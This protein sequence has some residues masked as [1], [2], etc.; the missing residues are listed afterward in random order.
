[1]PEPVETRRKEAAQRVQL[2]QAQGG[3]E[4]THTDFKNALE[5]NPRSHAKL[6]KHV[7]AFANTPRRTDAYIIFGV[8]EDKHLR[9]F[10]H[11]GVSESGFPAPETIYNLLRHYTTLSDVFVDAY[12]MLNGKLTPYVTIP[13][14]YEGPYA[15]SRSLQGAP[16]ILAAG[17][18]VCRYGSSSTRATERDVHRMQSDWGTWFL[19]CRYEKSAK[20]LVDTL[21]KRFPN[22]MALEDK[23]PYVRMV[24]G[25]AITDEFGTNVAPVLVHAYP[26]FESVESEAVRTLVADDAKPAFGKTLIGPRFSLATKETAARSGV[27]C[28]PLEEIYFVNDPYALLCRAFLQRWEKERSSHHIHFIVDLDYKPST[29]SALDGANRSILTFLEEQLATPE[30]VAI[31]IHG[32]FGGGKTTTAKQLVAELCSEYLRGN[33]RVPKVIYVD[34]NS[35]DVKSRRDECIEVELGKYRLP[36]DCVDGLITQVLEDE[37]HLIFDGV[38]EMARPNTPEGRQQALELLNDIGNRRAAIYLVRSS[39]FPSLADMICSVGLLADHD[40]AGAQKRLVVAHIL[41]LRQEQVNCYLDAR[42]GIEDARAVRSSLMQAKLDSFLEDPLIIS[43]VAQLVEAHGIGGLGALPRKGERAH[44]L[45][46]L[47]EQLLKREQTKRKRHRGLDFDQFQR[48]LHVVAFNL[49]CRG[50]GTITPPQL[51][52]FVSRAVGPAPDPVEAVN[53]FRTMSWIHRS[54]DGALSFRHEA[55]TVVCA[56]EHICTAFQYRNTLALGEW[57]SS[58]PLAPVVCDCASDVITSSGVLGATSMLGADL[59]FNIRTL[60]T[61]VLELTKDRKDFPSVPDAKQF[62]GNRLAEI[63]RG[64]VAAPSLSQQSIAILL[65]SVGEKRRMQITIPLLWLF[66][67]KDLPGSV[68]AAVRILGSKIRPKFDFGDE[69]RTVKADCSS[70]LDSMLLKELRLATSD[71]L[72]LAQ[73]ESLFRKMNTETSIDSHAVQ[74]ADRTLKSIEGE[75]QRREKQFEKHSRT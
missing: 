47:V 46:H 2:A 7:L 70:Y 30:R 25:S 34:V 72:E 18:I 11:T 54:D 74:Y 75:K 73:Y 71:L 10:E 12:F 59:P 61:D 32:D 49:V 14:Q 69:L 22:H 16:D 42:L 19:D 51:E 48:I 45:S 53:A 6:L 41:R 43:F 3:W 60:V 58:A 23:G 17:E 44:F 27:R 35:I 26:G 37:V 63:C 56:A 55:L 29:S 57:Q 39:Y 31:L 13:L 40:F 50:S 1:M 8:N 64:I 28:V 21:G 62:E 9:V 36:H 68:A 38:D 20:S 67:R 5:S 24:Y 4:G 65:S 52:A 15:L 66:A 33:T